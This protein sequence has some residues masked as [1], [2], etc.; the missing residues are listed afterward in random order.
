MGA[1]KF[2][3]GGG[4]HK[5]GERIIKVV[6]KP[7][8]SN[9]RIRKRYVKG[10]YVLMLINYPDSK[11]YEGNKIL[12]FEGVTV[13]QIK[14]KRRIDPHFKKK[15]ISPIARFEPTDKGCGN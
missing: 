11:N 8:P 7:D 4:S 3:S 2:F 12:L 10:D 14:R 15:G 6:S 1:I 13:D 9:Y 5:Q